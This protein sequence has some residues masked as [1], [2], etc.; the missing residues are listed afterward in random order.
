MPPRYKRATRQRLKPL[1][2]E[3]RWLAKCLGRVLID[4]EGRPFFNLV[5]SIRKTAIQLR[6]HYNPTVEAE[7]LKKIR[8]LDLDKITKV[9]RT[10]NVYFQLV[11]LAEDKHRIRR[12]R[13][14]EI[15]K[16]P[17]P[18]SLD[19]IVQKMKQS[20]ISFRA[21][22]KILSNLSIELILTAHPTEAQRR[23]ILEKLFVIDRL[24]F[25][26]EYHALIP[27]EREAIE[28]KIIEEIA[29]LWQTDEL[30]RRRQT[31]YDEVDSG[32]FYLDEVLFE[33]LPETLLRFHSLLEK[34]YGKRIPFTPFTRFGSWI[35]GDRDG[36]PFVNH[37]ATLE[38]IRRQKDVVL[39]KYINTLGDLLED[40]SQSIHLVG[41][42]QVLLHS[43]EEDEKILP[44]FS[45]SMKIKSQHEPYRKKVSFIQR[46]LINSLRLNSLEV[47]R[48]TAPD[49]TI[50]GHYPN[51]EAFRK[52]LELMI[53]S[54][55]QHHGEFLI[56]RLE[57]MCAKVELFGF[58][59]VKLDIRDNMDQLERAVAEIIASA[60][61]SDHPFFDLDEEDKV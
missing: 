2:A 43:I 16:R 18:G 19:D 31:V 23:S 36:N 9:I 24:L 56:R 52:D 12:K 29:L 4:Q 11:N 61:W 6:R 58:H 30:R 37:E 34:A 17:Q 1:H 39:R 55:R 13:A 51:A 48:R 25:E 15:E 7:L 27:R 35:G 47:Q 22:K 41:A 54:L 32:L 26:R 40:F 59:F 45:D 42:S 60:G 14:Y 5:E 49:E 44:L 21:V 46:K 28:T 33:V 20:K 8:T 57:L 10:F 50:E 38:T 3:V 53:D